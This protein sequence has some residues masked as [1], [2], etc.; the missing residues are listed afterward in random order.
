MV[1]RNKIFANHAKKARFNH[2][3]YNQILNF[4]F[5]YALRPIYHYSK[6][7]NKRPG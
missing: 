6:L 2:E 1:E 3:K 7:Q 5:S 4:F